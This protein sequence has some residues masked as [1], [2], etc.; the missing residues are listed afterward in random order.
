MDRK[1]L[2]QKRWPISRIEEYMRKLGVIKGVNYVPS[3]CYGYIEMWHHYDEATIL[4][5]LDYATEIGINSMRIFVSTAQ[6]QSH[7]DLVYANLERFLD[8][9][10]NRGISIMLSL[11][12]G[13]CIMLQRAGDDPCVLQGRW[14]RYSLCD[15]TQKSGRHRHLLCRCHQGEKGTWLGCGERH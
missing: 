9:C 13:T 3:Y 4:R 14:T 6:W 15:Q 11:A 10:K 1:Q 5:E 8:A 12:A 7:R 2:S